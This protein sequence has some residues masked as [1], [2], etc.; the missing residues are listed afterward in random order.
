MTMRTATI[1]SAGIT[2]LVSIV[3]SLCKSDAGRCGG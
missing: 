1:T 3:V 2:I